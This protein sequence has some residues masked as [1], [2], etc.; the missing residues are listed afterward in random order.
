MN[1]SI[2]VPDG[3]AECYKKAD[4]NIQRKTAIRDYRG[5]VL[6]YQWMKVWVGET[7]RSGAFEALGDN[8]DGKYRAQAP[9]RTFSV[10]GTTHTCELATSVFITL[11]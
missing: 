7:T 2:S 5:K 8:I 4:V 1:G 6:G 11:R 9:K 10:N 3:F